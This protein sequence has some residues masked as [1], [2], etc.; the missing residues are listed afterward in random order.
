[1]CYLSVHRFIVKDFVKRNIG[2]IFVTNVPVRST[3]I[4]CT[5]EQP[6]K[7]EAI[8]SFRKIFNELLFSNETNLSGKEIRSAK[9]DL[10][11]A[12]HQ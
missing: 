10:P 7:R 4:I 6:I 1:M 8:Q 3:T 11:S 12:D 9:C 5:K 2:K